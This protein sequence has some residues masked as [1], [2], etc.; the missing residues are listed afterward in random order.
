MYW[1][2]RTPC[3]TFK[4]KSLLNI[5][6][7]LSAITVRRASPWP[8]KKVFLQITRQSG[9]ENLIDSHACFQS[10]HGCKLNT[11]AWVVEF[12]YLHIVVDVKVYRVATVRRVNLTITTPYSFIVREGVFPLERCLWF[13][14]RR[15]DNSIFF[16]SRTCDRDLWKDEEEAVALP[17]GKSEGIP[18]TLQRRGKIKS[19]YHAASLWTA[20]PGCAKAMLTERAPFFL[21]RQPSSQGFSF[22]VERPWELGCLFA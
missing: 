17:T 18:V 20:N 4:T 12:T 10:S 15:I 22:P 9:C 21:V 5:V 13:S 16:F 7:W 1:L 11:V 8:S 6:E 3:D 14:Y 2:S 19:G